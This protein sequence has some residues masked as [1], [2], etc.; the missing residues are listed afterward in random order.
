MCYFIEKLQSEPRR[1]GVALWGV[2]GLLGLIVS[3]GT[4]WWRANRANPEA[5][6]YRWR[7]FLELP[8][9]SITRARLRDMLAPEPGEQVLEVGVGTGY[10]ALHAAR[11]LEPGGA[12]EILD[13]QPKMLDHATLRA[14]ERGVS[15]VL[16]TLGDAQ[17]LP[18]PDGS[19][20]AAYLV[21]TLGE[22]PDKGDALRELARVLAPGGRLV[23]GEALP[24]PHMVPFADLGSLAETAG[25]R[26]E[27][28]VGGKLGYLARFR[29]PNPAEHGESPCR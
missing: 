27:R 12:L 2:A 13:A 28:R 16:P 25:L 8:R 29:A 26:F 10:Y 4:V 21:A 3:G 1:R 17:A 14:R 7:L 9:P 24:D 15:N 18:Y 20:D 6:P 23:V 22:I 5:C 19:L 11:W